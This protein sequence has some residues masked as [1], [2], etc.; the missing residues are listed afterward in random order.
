MENKDQIKCEKDR[1]AR[2]EEEEE[3]EDKRWEKLGE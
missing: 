3:E 2:L 1:R